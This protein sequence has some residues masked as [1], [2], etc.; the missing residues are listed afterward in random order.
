MAA[1]VSGNSS[2]FCAHSLPL[3]IILI[4]CILN[5][6]RW[7]R[8]AHIADAWIGV[9]G[10]CLWL[11]H[12]NDTHLRFQVLGELPSSSSK[13]DADELKPTAR[14]RKNSA[15]LL[16]SD[17]FYRNLLHRYFRL[18]HRLHDHYTHWREAHP[19]FRTEAGRFPA[20][21]Q[22][23]Q[24]PV[25]NLF[26][27]I[28]SQN[29]HIARISTLVE[30]LCTLYGPKICDHEGH[31]YHAF[32]ACETLAQP[33]VEAALREAKFGYRA[34]FIQQSAGQI[35][36][37][38]GTEWFGRLRA[39]P[40]AEARAELTQLSG[41]GPKV[42]DCICLMS[43]NH[44][45]AIPVDTHVYQIAAQH[46]MPSLSASCKSITP[47]IY[48]TIGERFR[49]VYGPLAG[50]AQTVLFCADL[51]KFREQSTAPTE[52]VASK[53]KKVCK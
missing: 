44:L 12:Q 42:A 24:D 15:K 8:H 49:E 5:R 50:W 7:K 34:K 9:M 26:S 37:R 19:H 48:A 45:E 30:S 47:K 23:D 16:R 3:V 4:S 28:C 11:L 32:P 46:Y 38:G 33:A 52:A 35:V 21:R 25:E 22:L 18:D 40:Y 27:F 31:A 2:L 41:I 51:A 39:L 43:L 36:E 17:D 20:I 53:R 14:K 29:N 13:T 1:R 10:N 6:F